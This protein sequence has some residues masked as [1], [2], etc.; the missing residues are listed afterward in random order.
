MLLCAVAISSACSTSTSPGGTPATV[1]VVSPAQVSRGT[2]GVSPAT[3]LLVP[4]QA[5]SYVAVLE[6]TFTSNLAKVSW[7]VDDA[8]VAVVSPDGR[9]TAVAPG[10]TWLR[11]SGAD[12]I[13]A[14]PISVD[15][16]AATDAGG[17]YQIASCSA[18]VLTSCSAVMK[19]GGLRSPMNL[20]Y[21]NMGKL[22]VAEFWMGND[23]NLAALVGS[24][25]TAT[26]IRFGEPAPMTPTIA[27]G[28]GGCCGR[29]REFVVQVEGTRVMGG[30]FAYD[31]GSATYRYRLLARP[32]R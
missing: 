11:A 26:S 7:S 30:D 12:G 4:G 32:D 16:V 6:Q 19:A 23:R 25:E 31:T 20:R 21:R 9:L 10:F 22:V 13:A 29:L 18:P 28:A 8:S 24:T 15:A 3:A 1:P 2:L 17:D 27:L 5:V 14:H